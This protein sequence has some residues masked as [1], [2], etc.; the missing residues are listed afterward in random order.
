LL[1]RDPFSAVYFAILVG[2]GGTPD[3]V[4]MIDDKLQDGFIRV[5]VASRP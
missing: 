3:L 1:G 4:G 5:V 2:L